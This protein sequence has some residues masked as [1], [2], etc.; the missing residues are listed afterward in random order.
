[1]EGEYCRGGY[2]SR[3]GLGGREI[4]GEHAAF[5]EL[6]FEHRRHGRLTTTAH[7]ESIQ[8]TGVSSGKGKGKTGVEAKV[9]GDERVWREKYIR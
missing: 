2:K 3:G 8:G 6:L 7:C 5:D 9:R 1:V 4:H